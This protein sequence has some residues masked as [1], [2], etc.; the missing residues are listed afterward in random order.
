MPGYSIEAFGEKKNQ[1]CA[2]GRFVLPVDFRAFRF[3]LVC[4]TGQIREWP[5]L[6]SSERV[7]RVGC[8]PYCHDV[9]MLSKGTPARGKKNLILSKGWWGKSHS[10]TWPAWW[11]K[12]KSLY[13]GTGSL[14]HST[15]GQHTLRSVAM[16]GARLRAPLA[17]VLLLLLAR[18]F[19]HGATSG[20]TPD[21]WGRLWYNDFPLWWGSPWWNFLPPCV[22]QLPVSGC[23]IRK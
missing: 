8:V 12:K 19:L 5:A 13:N 20:E 1:L 15:I 18:L 2:C 7:W 21:A 6:M 11:G 10:T 17:L 4:G 3:E 23:W 9:T 16:A 22:Q 14:C